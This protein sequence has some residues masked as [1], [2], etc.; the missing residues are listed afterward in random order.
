M[1]GKTLDREEPLPRVQLLV[2]PSTKLSHEDLLNPAGHAFRVFEQVDNC[3][4]E[5][6]ITHG[7]LI[8]LWSWGRE[9]AQIAGDAPQSAKTLC[10]AARETLLRHGLVIQEIV[11][12]RE[13]IAQGH[14]QVTLLQDH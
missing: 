10:C 2:D 1:R 7:D 14:W 6:I 8:A 9:F 13:K 5:Q 11:T 4:S 3:G 12:H